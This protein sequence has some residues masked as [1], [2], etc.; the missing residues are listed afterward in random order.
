MA[1]ESF[2]EKCVVTEVKSCGCPESLSQSKV[3]E[4]GITCKIP[5]Q[6]CSTLLHCH[7][8]KRAS[9]CLPL[10]SKAGLRFVCSAHEGEK[11]RERERERERDHYGGHP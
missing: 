5:N 6:S 10:V 9:L 3:Y 2:P 11:E 8:Q 1:I 7:S 4:R